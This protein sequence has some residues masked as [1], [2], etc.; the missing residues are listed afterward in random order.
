V[1]RIGL[2]REA[3]YNEVVLIYLE[4]GMKFPNIS[5]QHRATTNRMVAGLA[6]VLMVIDLTGCGV[7]AAPCRVTSAAL[8]MVPVVGH[9]AALPTDACAAVIDP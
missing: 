5:L 7:M 2:E 9:V 1:L 8:K 6:I 4:S 3:G